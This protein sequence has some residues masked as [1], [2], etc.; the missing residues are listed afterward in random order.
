MSEMGFTG[1]ALETVEN[2]GRLDYYIDDASRIKAW[3]YWTCSPNSGTGFYQIASTGALTNAVITST[4]A[5]GVSPA[6]C[7]K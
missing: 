6:F 1:A 5:N 2:Q 3:T 4:A 7:V